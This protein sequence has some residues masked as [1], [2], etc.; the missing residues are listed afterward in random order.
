MNE[1]QITVTGWVA[2]EPFYTVTANG[3]PFLTVRVGCTPR[4]FDRRTGQWHDQ[5]TLFLTVNCWRALADNINASEFRRGHPVVVTGRLRIRQY[6]KDGQWRFSAEVEATTVGHDLTRGT[7]EF[8]AVQR[9]AVMDADRREARAVTDQWALASARAAGGAERPDGADEADGADGRPA[10]QPV[11]ASR[12]PDAEPDPQV[13][14]MAVEP[15]AAD[16]PSGSDQD[17]AA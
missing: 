13:P 17:R 2:A 3:T 6:E 4:R 12:A 14:L 10:E 16:R 1:A 7:A 9:G 15:P 8:R 11:Q 5:D